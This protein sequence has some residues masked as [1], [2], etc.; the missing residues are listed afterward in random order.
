M[1]LQGLAGACLLAFV[2]S[3]WAAILPERRFKGI[4]DAEPMNMVVKR[5]T[6]TSAASSTSSLVP[7][8]A[9]T[10]SAIDRACWSDG[11]SIATDFDQKH[12]VT[13][14]TVSYSLEITNTTC[15]PDG[16]G[17]QA[18]LLINNQYPG[19][20]I[21]ANWGDTLSITVTNSMQDNG[22]SIHWHGVRQLDSTGSDGVNGVTECALAPG[23]TRTYTFLCTQFGMLT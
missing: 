5:Q 10:N 8:A 2:S 3:S 18:C 16:H 21:T 17:D 7:D 12:P 1:H 6:S 14:K 19:P 15:N 23:Q 11:F 4:N 9:C 13:G 22:T 20:V